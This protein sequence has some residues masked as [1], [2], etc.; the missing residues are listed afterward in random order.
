[1]SALCDRYSFSG[2]CGALLVMVAASGLLAGCAGVGPSQ[3]RFPY[4]TGFEG[5][6]EAPLYTGAILDR[7]AEACIEYD[8]DGVSVL[9]LKHVNTTF[10]CAPDAV[11]GS[12]EVVPRELIRIVE[13]EYAPSPADCLCLFDVEYEIHHVWPDRY[14]LVVSEMYAGEG[15]EPFD[16]ELDL[17]RPC[18]GE[19]CLPR[20]GYPWDVSP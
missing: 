13:D 16:F 17:T 3:E 6:K 9:W 20:S 19:R 18:T 2:R 4:V 5:C 1:M 10:N 8:Y 12:V 15:N 7:G 11:G 14:R